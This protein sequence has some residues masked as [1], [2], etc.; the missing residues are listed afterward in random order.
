M[1]SE[2]LEQ[3]EQDLRLL[4]EEIALIKSEYNVLSYGQVKK[5][6]LRTFKDKQWQALFYLEKIANLTEQQESESGEE[7]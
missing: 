1:I 5:D 4:S 7:E 3:L 2:N 6:L